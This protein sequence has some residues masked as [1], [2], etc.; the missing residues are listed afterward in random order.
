VTAEGI[1]TLEQLE[2]LCAAA[3]DEG[4]GY[5]FGRPQPEELLNPLL[6]AGRLSLPTADRA[7]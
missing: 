1:E 6:A 3:C 2:E 7:P 4:Q 5:Y